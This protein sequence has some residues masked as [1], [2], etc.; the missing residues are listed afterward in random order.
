MGMTTRWA[1]A[2]LLG[3]TLLGGVAYAGSDPAA[4]AGTLSAPSTP[5]P[6]SEL[7][8][9]LSIRALSLGQ[10]T[11]PAA[12]EVERVTAPT[13][14]GTTR[15]PTGEIAKGVYISVMPACIPGVDEPLGPARRVPARRR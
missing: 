6:G 11:F 1:T 2:V 13:G 5:N 8:L 10:T 12:P 3:A 4:G 7:P 15:W 9:V 14:A